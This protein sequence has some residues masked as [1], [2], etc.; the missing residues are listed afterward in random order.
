MPPTKPKA[1]PK[2]NESKL[3]KLGLRTA[4]D[5]VLHLPMRYEDETE[6]VSIREAC[7]RGGHVS[8][9]EGIVIKNS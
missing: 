9:V 2:T 1:A 5:L 7:L 6:V 4:M 8:Q 3:A